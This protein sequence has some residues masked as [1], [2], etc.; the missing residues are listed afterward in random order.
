MD[1]W[2]IGTSIGQHTSS[3]PVLEK[4]HLLAKKVPGD[5]VQYQIATKLVHLF[6]QRKAHTGIKTYFPQSEK[7][8]ICSVA[9]NRVFRALIH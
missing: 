4:T 6:S 8:K 7:S 9:T 3:V 5:Y 1:G 2:T